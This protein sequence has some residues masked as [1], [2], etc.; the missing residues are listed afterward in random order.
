MALVQEFDDWNNEAYFVDNHTGMGY[1]IQEGYELV[2]VDGT[3]VV[4]DNNNEEY[5]PELCYSLKE[6]LEMVHEFL[7]NIKYES[8]KWYKKHKEELEELNEDWYA[9]A[10]TIQSKEKEWFD[11]YSGGVS[12]VLFKAD[13]T[14]IHEY[15]IDDETLNI[16][17]YY[18]DKHGKR[19]YKN[20]AY[21][22]KDIVAVC[23]NNEG[24]QYIAYND[25]GIDY[26][27]EWTGFPL[28]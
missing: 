7:E 13:G 9:N 28:I 20:N 18:S 19:I 15:D 21:N 1:E 16:G 4:Y 22:M 23:Y 14:Q 27:R 24:Y 25:K 17:S 5:L 2:D 10:Y 3:K 26:M 6:L 8:Q 12:F 11:W